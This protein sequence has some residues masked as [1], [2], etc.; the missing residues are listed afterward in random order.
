MTETSDSRKDFSKVIKD[1]VSDVLTTFPELKEKMNQ[2]LIDPD[3]EALDRVY[4]YCKKVFPERFFDILYQNVE[5]FDNTAL[6]IDNGIITNQYNKTSIEN[7]FAAGDVSN[8]YHPLYEENIRLE[9]WK[10]AQNHGVS[11]GKNI[12]GQKIEYSEVPWM[13]SDQYNLNLQLTGRCD[14]YDSLVKRGK[15][16][17]E[18]II[19]F[20]IITQ[21]FSGTSNPPSSCM[22]SVVSSP[23][24]PPPSNRP[25]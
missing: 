21:S 11:A 3:A 20:F 23:R 18:G 16:E 9:S 19:Y 7:V 22:R 1:L 17:N 15:D 24:K 14:E 8:F 2:D 10:H 25:S 5:I 13:W 6:K 4:E 12:V